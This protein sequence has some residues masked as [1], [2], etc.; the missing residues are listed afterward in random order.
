MRRRIRLRTTA[1]PK[2]FFTL[3]PKRVRGAPFAREKMTNCAEDRRR[4]LR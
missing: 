3:V 1:P 2:A 4:P